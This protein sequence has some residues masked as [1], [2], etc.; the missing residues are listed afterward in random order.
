MLYMLISYNT[1]VLITK[2]IYFRP[3]IFFTVWRTCRLLG[4]SVMFTENC[5]KIEPV[6]VVKL[7]SKIKYIPFFWTRCISTVLFKLKNCLWSSAFLIEY[8]QSLKS[9]NISITIHYRDGVTNGTSAYLQSCIIYLLAFK[10]I[11]NPVEIICCR[12]KSVKI[13]VN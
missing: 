3:D 6:I 10:V 5:K 11:A 4:Y 1:H 12:G 2:N 13:S 7:C 9:D 8:F